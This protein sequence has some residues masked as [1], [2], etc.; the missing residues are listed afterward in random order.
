MDELESY[1]L[2]A[3]R[4]E[5]LERS[6]HTSLQYNRRENIEIS[7]IPETVTD[8]NLEKTAVIILEA[9]GVPKIQAWQI[10]ACHRLKNWNNT[11]LRFTT[12][13]IADAALHNR[14]K[15]KSLNKTTIGLPEGTQLYINESLCRPY[16]FLNY[17]IRQALKRKDIYS[18]NLWKGRLS[19]KLREADRAINITHINDLISNIILPRKRISNFFNKN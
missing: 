10:H 15:L 12:R 8:E 9:V 6:H 13:K 18:Y 2:I 5:M 1:R 11:V 16:Q 7:G 14:N 17:K 4:V 3:K 19:I